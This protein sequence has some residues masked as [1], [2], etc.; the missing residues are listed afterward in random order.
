MNLQLPY[1][2]TL[3][4]KVLKLKLKSLY[5]FNELYKKT[6]NNKLN[7]YISKDKLFESI[8][9]I[10]KDLNSQIKSDRNKFFLEELLFYSKKIITD[11][12]NFESKNKLKNN[13]K[14]KTLSDL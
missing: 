6:E 10:F 12:L 14:S 8:D 3:R 2:I 13:D 11:D 4:L 1:K 7:N 9:K 5:D